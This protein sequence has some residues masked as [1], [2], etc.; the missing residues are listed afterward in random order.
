MHFIE[1]LPA[2]I[3]QPTEWAYDAKARTLWLKTDDGKSPAKRNVR[4]K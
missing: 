4:R 1:N 2:L 3:D